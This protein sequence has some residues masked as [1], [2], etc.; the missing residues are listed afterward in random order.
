MIP[1]ALQLNPE[2]FTLSHQVDMTLNPGTGKLQAS[3]VL[4]VSRVPAG[5]VAR[6]R[7]MPVLHVDRVDGAK[8]WQMHGNRLDVL[9]GAEHGA[10]PARCTVR[11]H[12]QVPVHGG[13][14][15]LGEDWWVPSNVGAQGPCRLTLHMPSGYQGAASGDPA[16]AST[17]TFG[18]LHPGMALVAGRYRVYHFRR[19]GLPIS[20]FLWPGD[21]ASPDD[22]ADRVDAAIQYFSR[23]WGAYPYRKIDVLEQ[24]QNTQAD[25]EPSLIRMAPTVLHSRALL[26]DYVPH[27][28]SHN[29]WGNA[30][31]GW[32]SDTLWF[33]PFAEFSSDLYRLDHHQEAEVRA[34]RHATLAQWTRTYG[35]K[36]STAIARLVSYD[37]A[38]VEDV[39][40][41][42]GCFVLSQLRDLMGDHDFRDGL[43]R[44]Y[45][46]WQGRTPTWTD[47][48]QSF[49][50]HLHWYFTQWLQRGDAADLGLRDV[51]VAKAG[52]AWQVSGRVVQEGLPYRLRVPI[53]VD[54]LRFQVDT[55]VSSQAFHVTVPQR[56]SRVALDPDE[57]VFR[58]IRSDTSVKL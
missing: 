6:F 8:S 27:E 43:R 1:L 36:G 21:P 37:G 40:Y 23:T 57:Q 47:I 46:T 32:S 26:D 52:L 24:G 16:G 48:E 22:L 34:E 11:Y 14:T 13:V 44:F 50:P 7:F 4:S 38:E 58:L 25:T 54:G 35:S 10:L 3:D 20:V 15:L 41:N 51:H 17:W 45:A 53:A 19:Q 56:P 9:F 2:P 31:V 28:V 42:K 12:G 5:G 39:A 55:W 33:E 49:G 29:W 18:P 30:V